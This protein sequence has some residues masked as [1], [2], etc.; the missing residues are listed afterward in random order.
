MSGSTEQ[1][2]DDLIAACTRIEEYIADPALPEAVVLD[3]VRM[4]LVDIASSARQ[5][6]PTMTAAEP[7]IPWSQ[8][9]ALGERLTGRH[10]ETPASLLLR[11]AR[12]DVPVLRDAA[13]RMRAR[14]PGPGR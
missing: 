2:L 12:T 5:L 1:R 8:V 14:C 10:G 9:S 4:R 13:I 6:P 7:T 3:A 11:T